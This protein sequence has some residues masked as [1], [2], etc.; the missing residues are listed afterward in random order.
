MGGMIVIQFDRNV[1]MSD[2]NYVN[3]RF[4]EIIAKNYTIARGS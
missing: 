3:F 1:N 2:N 4:D